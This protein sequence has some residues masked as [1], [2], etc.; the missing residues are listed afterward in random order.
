M[1]LSIAYKVIHGVLEQFEE[2]SPKQFFMDGLQT[3]QD[4][5]L[6]TAEDAKIIQLM[7]R[8]KSNAQWNE[9]LVKLEKSTKSRFVRAELVPGMRQITDRDR[10]TT[11]PEPE[12][13]S[14]ASTGA[15]TVSVIVIGATALGAAIGTAVGGPG[16]GTLVGASVGMLAGGALAA[17][18][19]EADG[20]GADLNGE[21]EGDSEGGG[22][23]GG[24][25]GGGA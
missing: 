19:V 17:A 23:G 20:D 18:A 5:K 15:G 25:E 22:E 4:H 11:Q 21:S 2:K 16:P 6:I 14:Y 1:T 7:P 12:Q 10:D 3:L 24:G 9:L 8:A 13:E